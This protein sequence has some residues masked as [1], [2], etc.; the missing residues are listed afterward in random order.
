MGLF[1]VGGCCR[2]SFLLYLYIIAAC[3][4]Y[5]S[6]IYINAMITSFPVLAPFCQAAAT[7][8]AAVA[9]AATAAAAATAATKTKV[10]PSHLPILPTCPTF[11]PTPFYSSF[12]LPFLP[13]FLLFSLPS[14]S[15]VPFL[16][17]IFPPLFLP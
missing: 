8:A 5:G 13:S 17:P 10:P 11:L 15:Y 4:C 3:L 1:C 7:A 9:V 16:R 6:C 12:F 14:L 2:L